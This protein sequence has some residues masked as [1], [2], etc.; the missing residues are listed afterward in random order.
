MK[1]KDEAIVELI[2]KWRRDKIS[3][4][5]SQ[6]FNM[7]HVAIG[8][9]LE[10]AQMTDER[11]REIL[12]SGDARWTSFYQAYGYCPFIAAS[13]VRDFT[14]DELRAIAHMMEKKNERVD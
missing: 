13:A 1:D 2:M 8:E 6:A 9:L 3:R 5:D 12:D 10:S 11:A 4:T 7:L 14:P